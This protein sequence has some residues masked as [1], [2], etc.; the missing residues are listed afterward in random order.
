V[1]LHVAPAQ[2]E[3]RQWCLVEGLHGH[4]PFAVVRPGVPPRASWLGTRPPAI[5][6]TVASSSAALAWLLYQL[7]TPLTCRGRCKSLM[8]RETSHAAPV[9]CSPSF[10]ATPATKFTLET[11]PGRQRER[12]PRR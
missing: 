9:R 7:T 5:V 6:P 11:P 12:K 3:F 1:E 8:A 10:G 2:R 4:R